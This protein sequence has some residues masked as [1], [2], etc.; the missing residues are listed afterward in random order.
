MGMDSDGET[1]G[2][3]KSPL[4][5]PARLWSIPSDTARRNIWVPV[6]VIVAALP[7]WDSPKISA[8][9]LNRPDGCKERFC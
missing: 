8:N 9:A 2:I 6:A 3:R 1:V 5:D 4:S 7:A